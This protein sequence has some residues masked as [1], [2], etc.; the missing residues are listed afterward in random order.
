[1][2]CVI[3]LNC[4]SLNSKLPVMATSSGKRHVPDL[5]SD[6]ESDQFFSYENYSKKIENRVSLWWLGS[7]KVA[8]V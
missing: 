1:M 4:S 5:V 3:A 8:E 6:D 7:P 2:H